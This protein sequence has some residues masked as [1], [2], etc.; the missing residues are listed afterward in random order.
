VAAP[1]SAG[2]LLEVNLGR[3]SAQPGANDWPSLVVVAVFAVNNARVS[4]YASA[5]KLHMFALT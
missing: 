1:G 4:V 3:D 2:H 5:T